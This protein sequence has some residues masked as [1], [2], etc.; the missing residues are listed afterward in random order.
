MFGVRVTVPLSGLPIAISKY[1]QMNTL[2]V[3]QNG[4]PLVILQGHI[5]AHLAANRDSE[6]NRSTVGTAHDGHDDSTEAGIPGVVR[7]GGDGGKN[8]GRRVDKQRDGD[9]A[10]A[11]AEVWVSDDW[12]VTTAFLIARQH[13]ARG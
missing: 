8:T 5:T 7:T 9:H 4:R 11:A 6:G 13:G 1:N 3:P 2:T 10:V 12:N